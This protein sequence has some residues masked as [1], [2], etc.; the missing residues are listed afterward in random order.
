L[1]AKEF[2]EA[3]NPKILIPLLLKIFHINPLTASLVVSKAPDGTVLFPITE[4]I[5]KMY[6]LMKTKIVDLDVKLF[7]KSLTEKFTNSRTYKIKKKNRVQQWKIEI[8]NQKQL[9]NK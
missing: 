5:D 4:K 8:H 6:A 3:S 7:M 2:D 1:V 9:L